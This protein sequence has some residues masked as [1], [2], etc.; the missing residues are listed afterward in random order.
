MIGKKL[1]FITLWLVLASA[2]LL[3]TGSFAA[4][5]AVDYVKRIVSTSK[6]EQ[7][8]FSSNY[9]YLVEK[10]EENYSHRW[11][12]PV[13]N[14]RDETCAI[15]LWVNNYLYGMID[16]PNTRDISYTLKVSVMD[17]NGNPLQDESGITVDSTQPSSYNITHKLQAAAQ[18]VHNEHTISVSK[19]LV[20][21]IMLKIVAEPTGDSYSATGNQKLAAIIHLS[22]GAQSSGWKGKFIDKDKDIRPIAEYDGYNYEISGTGE[23]T[24]ILR[25][26]KALQISPWF[27]NQYGLTPVEVD[28]R[29]QISMQV[30]GQDNAQQER[31]S[32]Y[33]IQF[34]KADRAVI[35]SL[36][37]P[38]LEAKVTVIPPSD[39]GTAG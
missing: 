9:L 39:A 34:Y 12:T 26:D 11:V 7:P 14:D 17:T 1:N 21:R 20:G 38:Q 32:A 3:V 36:T 29:W 23:G 18:G 31:P 22:D 15:V 37:W 30:G 16:E 33:Q 27:L 6:G 25:W 28:G 4:Y 5:T 2:A 35:D 13:M 24:L 10:N 19:E 8:R